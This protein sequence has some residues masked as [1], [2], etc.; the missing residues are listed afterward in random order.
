MAQATDERVAKH[1]PP[2]V[3]QWKPQHRHIQRL[4]NRRSV[5]AALKRLYR[6][7]GFRHTRAAC[8]ENAMVRRCSSQPKQT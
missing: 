7:W 8:Y 1:H 4:T 2:D 3:Y 6:S 5:R